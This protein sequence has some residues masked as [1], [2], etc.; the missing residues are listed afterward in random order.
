M[1][2]QV[3]TKDISHTIK[4]LILIKDCVII[5]NWGALI[6]NPLAVYRHP[7]SNLIQ[8]EGRNIIFNTDINQEDACLSSALINQFGLDYYQAR[9]CIADYIA[10]AKSSLANNQSFQIEGL[11]FFKQVS[12][13]KIIFQKDE[14]FVGIESY[15]LRPVYA[16]PVL[17]TQPLMPVVSEE[18]DDSHPIQIIGLPREKYKSNRQFLYWIAP[19]VA[20]SVF[21][22]LNI[23]SPSISGE[24]IVQFGLN[25]GKAVKAAMHIEQPKRINIYKSRK[26]TVSESTLN[27]M[28]E[29]A[30]FYPIAGSFASFDNAQQFLADLEDI[31]FNPLIVD[32]SP[33]GLYRVGYGAFDSFSKANRELEAIRKSINP[34]AWLLVK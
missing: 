33:G 25:G 26:S 10:V 27:F 30:S 17:R 9:Q 12:N 28:L 20:A 34:D 3:S 8:P 22:V 19:A 23:F 13:Q 16:I 24:Q 11:G 14:L 1:S 2:N 7:V 5:P 4:Q 29:T 18:H 32:R 15:G 31:G 6:S 21:V